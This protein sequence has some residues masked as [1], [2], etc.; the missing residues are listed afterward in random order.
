MLTNRRSIAFRMRPRTILGK[1]RP[2]GLVDGVYVLSVL[3]FPALKP[4]DTA[5]D[6]SRLPSLGHSPALKLPALQRDTLSNGLKIVLAERHEIPVVNFWLE[7][8][9]GFAADQS[10]RPAP[11]R[12]MSALLTSGTERRT[13]LADQR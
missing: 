11:P 4:E 10:A 12:L 5:V 2:P 8:D 3:P 6:R 1:R 9:A 13:A 7:V